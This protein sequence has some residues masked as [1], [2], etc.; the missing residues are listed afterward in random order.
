MTSPNPLRIG[1]STRLMHNIPAELGFRGKTLQY[2]EQSFAH[3]IMSHGAVALMVPTLSYDGEVPRRRVA[4]QGYVDLLDGLMLQGGLDVS[5]TNYGEEPLRPEWTGDIIRDRYEIELIEGFLAAGK[6]VL[7]ICRG[8][9]LINVAFGGS[10]YQD[11]NFQRP[12]ARRHVDSEAYDQ[13]THTLDIVPG[14]RLAA[15]YAEALQSSSKPVINS[16]HHQAVNRL[17]NGLVAEGRSSEDGIVEA[18]RGET[19]GKGGPWVAGVQWHPE[20]HWRRSDR[21]DPEPLLNDFLHAARASRNRDTAPQAPAPAT[22]ATTNST[23]PAVPAR[24][25]DTVTST[26]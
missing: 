19:T 5:P 16:I 26:A 23:A 18:I 15:L 14:T 9:Q 4:L 2:L 8:C 7:G 6:P 11:I 25:A 12:D 13:W 10:L 22:A 24:A 1:I 3:W 17:G 20:F 21:L